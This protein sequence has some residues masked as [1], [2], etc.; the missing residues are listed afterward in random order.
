[1]DVR[2]KWTGLYQFWFPCK[3]FLTAHDVCN[4]FAYNLQRASNPVHLI[5]TAICNHSEMIIS[6]IFFLLLFC[7]VSPAFMTDDACIGTSNWLTQ[8]HQIYIFIFY[9]AALS[10][11][12]HSNFCQMIVAIML[13]ELWVPEFELFCVR[14]EAMTGRNR[15]IYLLIVHHRMILS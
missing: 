9:I 3:F 4:Y 11:S 15:V 8:V 7:F 2:I 5:V 12:Y 1:M 14:F 6:I 10:V 13:I